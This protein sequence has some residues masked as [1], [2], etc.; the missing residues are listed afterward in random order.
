MPYA[1]ELQSRIL[2]LDLLRA[3]AAFAVVLLHCAAPLLTSYDDVGPSAWWTGNLYDSAVR[4]CVPAFVM[5]S[6]ALLLGRQESLSVFW[7]R[8]AKKVLVPLVFWSAVY[9]LWAWARGKGL[10]WHDLLREPAYFHLWFFYM[11]LGLYVLT[12]ILAVFVRGAAGPLLT[13]ALAVWFVWA[14]VL[15]MLEG[16]FGVDLPAVTADPTSPLHFAGYYLLGFALRDRA[17]AER[18]ERAMAWLA[19]LVGFTGTALGTYQQTIVSGAGA[20]DDTYYEYLSSNVVLMAVGVFALSPS[21][22]V[23]LATARRQKT[24]L[25]LASAAL[26]IYLVHV[27]VLEVVKSGALGF[28]LTPT[29]A[30]PAVAVPLLALLVYSVSLA[31][32]MIMRRTPGL[33]AVVP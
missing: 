8:R 21:T 31:I 17:F 19:V 14:S 3:A 33:R 13:Y 26:G 28:A 16:I 9:A 15:P 7:A 23:W 4:W 27:M 20:F 22:T 5:L 32:V 18:R 1:S 30:H 11:I 10:G 24:V 6:G 25:A 12:P 29:S 2:A